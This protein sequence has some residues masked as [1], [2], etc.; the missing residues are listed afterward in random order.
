MTVA[1]FR[2]D[3][4]YSELQEDEPFWEQ[5]Y[6]R[7]FPYFV[8]MMATPGKTQ[9]QQNGMDRVIAL[10]DD[11]LV[12]IDEKKLKHNYDQFC[13]EYISNDRTKTPGWIEKPLT[14]HFIAYAFM[15]SRRVYLLPWNLLRHAWLANRQTWKDRAAR[16]EPGYL[17]LKTPNHGYNTISVCVP[18]S[19][20][21]RAIAAVAQAQIIQVDVPI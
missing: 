19:E 3:L 13:L 18:I 15:P 9:A 2:D 5:V 11:R 4:A 1:S 10:A 8:A 12:R 20:V 17:T 16:N 14:V 7:A 21:Y 6:R